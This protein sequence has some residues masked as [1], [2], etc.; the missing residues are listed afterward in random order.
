MDCNQPQ[1][2]TCEV[3]EEE[4]EEEEEEDA[5]AGSWLQ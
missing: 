1:R 2:D 3:M 4:E 5:T